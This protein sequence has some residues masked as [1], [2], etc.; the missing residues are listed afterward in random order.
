M[1]S[2]FVDTVEQLNERAKEMGSDSG[3]SPALFNDINFDIEEMF[4]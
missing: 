4:N 2:N 1:K 3:V